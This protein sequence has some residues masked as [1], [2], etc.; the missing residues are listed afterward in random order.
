MLSFHGSALPVCTDVEFDV[1]GIFSCMNSAI[2]TLGIVPWSK[3]ALLS[4]VY[5]GKSQEAK[6]RNLSRLISAA[7]FKSQ[8]AKLVINRWSSEQH[9]QTWHISS[10]SI[11]PNTNGQT[12]QRTPSKTYLVY[13]N[14]FWTVV[15]LNIEIFFCSYLVFSGHIGDG[16]QEM[17]ETTDH[18]RV[19]KVLFKAS[20]SGKIIFY[21]LSFSSLITD[22][23]KTTV[24]GRQ[25]VSVL[26][27]ST[28]S[29][30]LRRLNPLTHGVEQGKVI[31]GQCPHIT[32]PDS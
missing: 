22:K 27:K 16:H 8:P 31:C 5:F 24:G 17:Q 18:H 7:Y 12:H 6:N 19:F 14:S 26:W 2:H 15:L 4:T 9:T 20:G 13:K 11:C 3:P 23:T 30:S 10:G 28:E 29:K 32:D 21:C 1:C 25:K